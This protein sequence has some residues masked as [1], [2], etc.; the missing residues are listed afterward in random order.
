MIEQFLDRQ[1]APLSQ[2]QWAALDQ[3]AVETARR[4]LVGRRFI[5][6]FGPLGPGVQTV[7]MDKFDGAHMGELDLTGEA[8]CGTIKTSQI[9]HIT[10]PIIHKDFL[11]LWRNVATG[12]QLGLP[13]D[14]APAS[15]AAAFAARKED[16]LIFNGDLEMGLEGLMT[17]QGRSILPL[18]DW[19]QV[20]NAFS[21][22]TAAVERLV[23]L[24]FYG[25]YALVVPP[26]LYARMHGVHERTGVL[27]IRNVEELTT[28]GVFRSPVIADNK[29]LIVAT[30][31]Q[32]L[33]LAIAQDM[34]VAYLGPEK[35][36]HMLRVLEILALRIK[37]AQA[38]VTLEA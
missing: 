23:S 29:A 32:N 4:S 31:A 12:Q 3:A 21:D 38:I 36:N 33:D 22:V 6:L 37:R 26:V 1:A 7:P 16:D 15:S 35:M 2:E 14:M 19:S 28:G 10:L 5:P 34:V 8:E 20:G 27:E 24:G 17:V 11:L 25:P 13:L 9:R 30:G 18:S